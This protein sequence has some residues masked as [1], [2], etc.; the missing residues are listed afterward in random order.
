MKL[1][2]FLHG[3]TIMHR[4]A[5]GRTRAER[6]QQVRD[7]E[8]SVRDF[9]AYIP[10][11]DAANKLRRW[12]EQGA[13]IVYLS[14]HQR[15]DDVD[16]DQTVLRAYDFPA[17]QVVFRQGGERYQDLAERVRPDVLIEDDCESIGGA[18]QMVY[19]RL[20]AAIQ[21]SMTSITVKEFEGIDHLP[22]D[23]A[24]LQ[25]RRG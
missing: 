17:G 22:D 10:V 23:L 14:S 25:Q 13:E 18:A 4:S 6:V 3:T 15:Q 5:A 16:K 8:T 9:A 7:K 2:I 20:Q 24:T 21:A 12:N 19:P 1:L 11:G